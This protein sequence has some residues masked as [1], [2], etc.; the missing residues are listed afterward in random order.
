MQQKIY[1]NPANLLSKFD[2]EQDT[3]DNWILK[4]QKLFKPHWLQK[5][6]REYL[7]HLLALSE[8]QMTLH[9]AG[10]LDNQSSFKITEST[11]DLLAP[12]F[13]HKNKSV[14]ANNT[15]CYI[16]YVMVDD[17]FPS[18]KSLKN[19]NYDLIVPLFNKYR[20]YDGSIPL[21]IFGRVILFC[22][23][24]QQRVLNIKKI[25]IANT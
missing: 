17:E 5:H 18:K 7:S 14:N 23:E 21:R 19:H 22:H 11:P 8:E 9:A 1:S 13:V 20:F 16:K 10:G 6:P 2:L 12:T 24:L 4:S 3:V 25:T 15:C